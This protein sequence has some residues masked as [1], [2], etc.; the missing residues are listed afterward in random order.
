MRL[1]GIVLVILGVVGLAYGGVTW[2]TKEK[3]VDLG[4]LQVSHDKTQSLPLPPIAGGICL[5]AGVVLLVAAGRQ[6]S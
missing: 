3:V 2:T 1:V 4:P 5:I 6:Q